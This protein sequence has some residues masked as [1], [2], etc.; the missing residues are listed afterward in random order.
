MHYTHPAR[1]VNSYRPFICY[2][3]R[4]GSLGKSARPHWPVRHT[5]A[6][7]LSGFS[8]FVAG[9]IFMVVY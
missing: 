4:L 2:M 6:I 9:L 1:A 8:A 5:R 7:F 3:T